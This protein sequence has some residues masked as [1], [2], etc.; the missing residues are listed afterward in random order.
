MIIGDQED[1]GTLFS[2]F[3]TDVNDSPSL[4]NWLSTYMFSNATKAQLTQLVNTYDTAISSGSPFRTSILN[5]F[6]PGFKRTAALLGDLVFTL[7]RRME[8]ATHAK[9]NPSVPTWSYLASYDY[10]TPFLGTFHASDILQV[11]YGVL[12]DNAMSSARAYFFNFIYNLDPN[13]GTTGYDTWP[14]WA[15]NQELMWFQ[16]ADSND[17]LADNFRNASYQWVVKNKAVLRV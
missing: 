3:Q 4:V 16:S 1:E 9:L 7:T 6:Y 5:E 14:K 12:P 10:G 15:D 13:V 11:F 8:L 17:L 2:V